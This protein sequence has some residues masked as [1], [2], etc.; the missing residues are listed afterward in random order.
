[1][2]ELLNK[3][4][5]KRLTPKLALEHNWL[6]FN[7]K[8]EGFSDLLGTTNDSVPITMKKNSFA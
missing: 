7:A 2:L 1:M 5:E 4:P 3:N 8:D 6:A